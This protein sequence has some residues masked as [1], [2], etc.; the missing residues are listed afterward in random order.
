MVI[1][2]GK[3]HPL[4]LRAVLVP[5]EAEQ[6]RLRLLCHAVVTLAAWLV[7]GETGALALSTA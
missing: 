5:R 3:G 7:T 6:G 1:L 4:L 2:A